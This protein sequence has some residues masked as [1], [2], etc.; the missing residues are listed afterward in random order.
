M[1][2]LIIP[3]PQSKKDTP[4][5]TAVR[6]FV[7]LSGQKWMQKKG[8]FAKFQELLPEH[9]RKYLTTMTAMDWLPLD[10]ALEVYATLDRLEL[11]A[12]EQVELGRTVSAANNGLVITTLSRLAGGVGV[13]PWFALQHAHRTWLRSNRG[14][15]IAVYKIADKACRL[16]FWQ[17]PL[18]RSPFFVTSMRGAIA[19]GIEPFCK[20]LVVSE[21]ATYTTSDGFALRLAW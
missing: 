14:G 9:L 16:E 8:V 10:D 17:V 4:P 20:R 6:A 18:A 12:S 19:V 13:T 15:A 1:D 11:N 5:V 7:F 2:E 21:L 3:P